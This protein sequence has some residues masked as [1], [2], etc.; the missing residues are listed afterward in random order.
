LVNIDD[1]DPE[2]FSNGLIPNDSEKRGIHRQNSSKLV[3]TAH[4]PLISLTI[5][6]PYVSLS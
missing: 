5:E 6:S 3:K 2:K 1:R 4:N